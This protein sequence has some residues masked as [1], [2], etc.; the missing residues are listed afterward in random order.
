MMGSKVPNLWSKRKEQNLDQ[1]FS[2]T[3]YVTW[4]LLKTQ[5]MAEKELDLL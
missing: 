5:E 4:L 1:N 2:Q 3:K